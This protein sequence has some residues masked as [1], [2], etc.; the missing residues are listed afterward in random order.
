[1]HKYTHHTVT[2]I[3]ELKSVHSKC[4][5]FAFSSVSAEY[6]AENLND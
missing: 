6:L 4:N 5:L 3:G 2:R 1:M